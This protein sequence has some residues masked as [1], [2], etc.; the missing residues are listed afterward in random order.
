[1]YN[2]KN[3]IIKLLITF[4]LAIISFFK[5]GG[6][7]EAASLAYYLLFAIFPMSIFTSNL[8]GL[9]D[10][11]IVEITN[12]L[13][14]FMPD[15]IVEIVETYLEYV[16]HTASTSL[17]FF[18]LIFSI[19]FPMRAVKV[20]MDNVHKAYQLGKPHSAKTYFIRQFVYTLLLL[21]T[22]I[23]M[24]LILTLG[25]RVV[26][27]IVKLLSNDTWNISNYILSLWKY[28]RF[29]LVGVLMLVILTSLY[30]FSLE[31]KQPMR[32][33]L[34]G[35]IASLL[36]WMIV[37]VGFSYYVENLMDY[38][39]LY[40]SLGTV[41]VLMIWLYL[42]AMVLLFGLEINGAIVQLQEN[43]EKLNQ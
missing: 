41:I 26:L 10:L 31:R 35:I 4:K 34:P 8:I 29:I 9:L 6:D 28:Y 5:H 1:M 21:F 20:L 24:L 17:F 33:V 40:G 30:S 13:Y 23:M 11:D 32:Y 16:T 43:N 37:S 12:F 38:S 19:W 25:E 3:R 14:H 2:Y 18:S 42:T 7:K 27:Q 36:I 39:I 22:I 15:A